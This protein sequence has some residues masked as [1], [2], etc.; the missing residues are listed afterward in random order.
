MLYSFG[1]MGYPL[2]HIAIRVGG[3]HEISFVAYRS[4][5]GY[6]VGIHGYQVRSLTLVVYF[7]LCTVV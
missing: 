3:L 6:P 2:L 1:Y 7:G 4:S 5:A